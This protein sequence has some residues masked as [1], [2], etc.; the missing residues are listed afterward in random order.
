MLVVDLAASISCQECKDTVITH[1]ATETGTLLFK[2]D[3]ITVLQ[4]SQVEPEAVE[5]TGKEHL[6]QNTL[7]MELGVAMWSES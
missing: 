7:T 4:E 3:W 1:A 6:H 5:G 2:S